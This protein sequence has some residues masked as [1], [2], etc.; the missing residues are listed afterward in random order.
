M[1]RGGTAKTDKTPFLGL[2]AVL[3]VTRWRAFDG[4]GVKARR[5][6]N[7]RLGM[8][9][10]DEIMP[11]S[12]VTSHFKGNAWPPNRP[13]QTTANAIKAWREQD[14]SI[15]SANRRPMPQHFARAFIILGWRAAPWYFRCNCR[16]IARWVNR[17]GKEQL[18]AERAAM[19]RN[20]HRATL[21][22]QMAAYWTS[23]PR[24]PSWLVNPADHKSKSQG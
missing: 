11:P 21:L 4:A 3:A 1:L 7:N 18:L 16:V 20:P 12:Y 6:F 14:P 9:P 23:E 15:E 19:R 24:E 5:Y 10:A 22:A 17:C 13:A 8:E 2:S